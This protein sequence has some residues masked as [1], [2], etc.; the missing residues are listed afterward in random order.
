MIGFNSFSCIHEHL[1]GAYYFS[2]HNFSLC[3][4]LPFEP[5]LIRRKNQVLILSFSFEVFLVRT[6][7]MCLG[8]LL[9]LNG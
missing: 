5:F 2:S 7:Q 6:I 3:N 1:F 4:L 9:I 8:F